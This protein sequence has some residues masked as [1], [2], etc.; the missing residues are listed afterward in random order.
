MINFIIGTRAQ[1]FKMAP[2]MLECE[3]HRLKW[4]WVYTA[5]HRDTVAETIKT[6]GLPKP[7]YTVVHWNTEAKTM[8][9]IWKWFF[10]M[11]LALLRSRKI[12]GGYTGSKNI[13]LTHGDTLTTWLAALMGRLTRTKVM[14]IES[15]LRSF[16]IFK[17]FPE[18]INRL[19]TFRL[20]NYYACPGDWAMSNL[21]KYKGR[22]IN[23]GENTQIDTIRFG[24]EHAES[25]DI[26]IPKGKYVAASIHRYENIFKTDRLNKVVD[27]LEDV[28]KTFP[29]Y[30][31]QHPATQEQLKK[32]TQIKKRLVANK[33][34]HLLPRLE[35]LPFIKL[36]K[37]SEFVITDGGGNQEELYHMGKPTLLFRNETE[38]QEGLGTTAII[39][40]LDPRV[41]SNFVNNYKKYIRSSTFDKKLHPSAVIVE[42]LQEN[43]F[44]R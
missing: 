6:F 3:K 29:V 36:I 30:M 17:P 26:E 14:H 39:S 7:A 31:V 34:I 12:L 25:G 10:K 9:K 40:R 11:L 37:H 28:A 43:G 8:G 21:A 38:R 2:I 4:R 22:K 5:Q 13:V 42:F 35:Y 32:L 41:I 23:T 18:E 33:D 16:N 15:G 1:L 20:A 24:Y 19:I 27:R 44:G